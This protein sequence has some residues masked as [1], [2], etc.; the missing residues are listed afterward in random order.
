MQGLLKFEGP[1]SAIAAAGIAFIGAVLAGTALSVSL[2]GSRMQDR[3]AEARAT[4]VK[5]G[6]RINEQ[7]NRSL[8][9]TYALAAVFRP[10]VRPIENFDSVAA[11]MLK[12]YP[13]VSSLQLAPGGVVTHVMPLAGNEKVLGHNLLADAKRN[14][15]AFLAKE[16]GRLTV[17]GP[18]PLI[19]GGEGIIGRL[20]VFLPQPNGPAEFWG[21][22]TALIRL[23]RLLENARLSELA[24]DGYRYELWRVHADTGA[25]HVFAASPEASFGDP[26]VHRF[27]VPNGEWSLS[28]EPQGGWLHWGWIAMGAAVTLLVALAAARLAHFV[29]RD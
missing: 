19:Q 11:A 2:G 3:K 8:S 18:F 9:A 29:L 6:V 13:D 25:R 12:N 22:S 21:F 5:Y 4:A 14:K 16:T 17:A 15:E 26:V 23:P 1:R 20:P 28:V 24:A 7:L 10:G 27:S